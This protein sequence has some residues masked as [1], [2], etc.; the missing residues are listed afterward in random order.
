MDPAVSDNSEEQVASK[1][2][3][4]A[5]QTDDP[6]IAKYRIICRE[7]SPPILLRDG[8]DDL[9]AQVLAVLPI[10]HQGE[11][12][13]CLVC[14]ERSYESGIHSGVPKIPVGAVSP[15]NES[16]CIALPYRL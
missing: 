12:I 7:L 8:A 3:R 2:Q 9:E 11:A 4:N 5:D 6:R 1:Q 15:D 14:E 13:A 16:E 10:R